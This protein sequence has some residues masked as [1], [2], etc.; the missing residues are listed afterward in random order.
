MLSVRLDDFLYIY[1][2]IMIKIRGKVYKPT[3]MT[4]SKIF[5]SLWKKDLP[6]N[7]FSIKN[8]ISFVYPL[9][10]IILSDLPKSTI[11]PYIYIYIYI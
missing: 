11:S 2:Y 1:I 5:R 8:E 6:Q 9:I 10:F 3:L 7:P 4:D